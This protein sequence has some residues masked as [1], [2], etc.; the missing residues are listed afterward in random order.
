MRTWQ[1]F[2]KLQRALLSA[3]PS[4]CTWGV[5]TRLPT[6]FERILAD[7]GRLDAAER[8]ISSLCAARKEWR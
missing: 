2:Q 7:V 1:E 5:S 8:G 3:H 4:T 6:A